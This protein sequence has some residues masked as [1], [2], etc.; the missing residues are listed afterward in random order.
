MVGDVC[1]HI[2]ASDAINALTQFAAPGYINIL[3]R[4]AGDTIAGSR[5]RC[6]SNVLARNAVD[7]IQRAV[8]PRYGKVLA[9][10][11][12]NAVSG[13]TI[14]SRR[15]VLARDAVDA[16]RQRI[17]AERVNILPRRTQQTIRTPGRRL[18][19]ARSAQ[20]LHCTTN[21]TVVSWITD[22]GGR[23]CN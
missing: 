14:A 20:R 1:A 5:V 3:S 22:I 19:L 12:I 13:I 9:S 16:V 23:G 10:H 7:A 6:S 21:R 2:F 8:A 15:D 17:A 4:R 18:V 11:A